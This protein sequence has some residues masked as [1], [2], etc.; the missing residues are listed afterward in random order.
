MDTPISKPYI[1]FSDSKPRFIALL[2]LLTAQAIALSILE[3]LLPQL[4]G[5][6]PGVKLGLSNIVTMYSASVLGVIPT[7]FIVLVKSAVSGSLRGGMYFILSLTGGLVSSLA[8]SIL[9]KLK[10]EKL[11]L[12]GI[13]IIGS[14][15][16]NLTQLGLVALLLNIPGLLYYIPVLVISGVVMGSVT[17]LIFK[18]TLPLL[19]KQGVCI[20]SRREVR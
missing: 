10:Q 3:A 8:M 14:L 7:F 6:V 20:R 2:G 18:C 19:N 1:S 9:F 16:H 13:S 12:M 4:P 5:L 11:G 15:L 17:G